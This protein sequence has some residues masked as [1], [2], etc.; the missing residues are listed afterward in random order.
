ME[1]LCWVSEQQTIN[2]HHYIKIFFL[3]KKRTQTWKGKSWVLHLD[4]KPT[5]WAWSVKKFGTKYNMPGL[6]HLF[7]SLDPFHASSLLSM[8]KCVLNGIRF[9]TFEAV[10]E[11]AAGNQKDLKEDNF[12]H[13]FKHG[14]F[15]WSI[16]SIKSKQNV[17]R[18]THLIISPC[19]FLGI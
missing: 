18:T 19:S 8:M 2:H 15:V 10:K 7:Y 17:I 9:E 5:Y 3:N 6:G 4:N 1:N 11:K 12:Q 16:I 14:R 13:C